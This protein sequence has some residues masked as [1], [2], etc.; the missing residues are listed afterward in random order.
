MKFKASLGENLPIFK[1]FGGKHHTP[2]LIPQILTQ[3][4]EPTWGAH[5]CFWRLMEA[6]ARVGQLNIRLS[7]SIICA[8]LRTYVVCRL[9][10]LLAP[11]N[12]RSTKSTNWSCQFHYKRSIVQ[13]VHGVAFGPILKFFTGSIRVC[14]YCGMWV[15]CAPST[16]IAWPSMGTRWSDSRWCICSTFVWRFTWQEA[17]WFFKV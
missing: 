6:L 12:G 14:Q 11:R 2:E 9:M 3:V 10:Q 8:L 5:L 17:C 16:N 7:N 4:H 13:S 15:P 1:S